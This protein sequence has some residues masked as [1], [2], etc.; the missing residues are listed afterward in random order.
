MMPAAVPATA[1]PATTVPATTV[2]AMSPSPATAKAN[3]K[4]RT[5]NGR[6]VITRVIVRIGEVRVGRRIGRVNGGRC[7]NGIAVSVHAL[8]VADIV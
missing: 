8:G 7:L 6:A 4:G 1:V 3:G 5:E 2:P